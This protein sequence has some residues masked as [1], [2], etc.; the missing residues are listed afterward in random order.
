MCVRAHIVAHACTLPTQRRLRA[1]PGGGGAE[2]PRQSG[3]RA[4]GPRDGNHAVRP[5]TTG[6]R[7][8]PLR[9]G[10]RPAPTASCATSGRH[11]LS[12]G[13][14]ATRVVCQQVLREHNR[15]PLSPQSG[16]PRPLT[17]LSGD[18][19]TLSRVHCWPGAPA[20]PRVPLLLHP[21]PTASDKGIIFAFEFSPPFLQ[22]PG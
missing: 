18:F 20:A 15:G 2:S 3:G 7:F 22:T 5:R 13:P 17:L 19:G 4:P 8:R 14:R 12:T 6:L 11:V 1:K 21:P 10:A 16:R 9:A